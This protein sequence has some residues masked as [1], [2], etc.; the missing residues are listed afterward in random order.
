MRKL[1][2]ASAFVAPFMFCMPAHALMGQLSGQSIQDALGSPSLI[3]VKG[4]RGHGG[5]H[6]WGRGHGR[7][8]G[9]SR[10]RKVGW[11]GYH[12]PPGQARKG[13]C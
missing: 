6:G 2:L 4:G 9:W 10:G 8:Y 5:G 12:C 13:R 7:H 1:I 3:E 11:R